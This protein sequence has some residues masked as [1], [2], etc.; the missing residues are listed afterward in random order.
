MS[1][2]MN[3]TSAA[4]TARRGTVAAFPFQN[5]I[6]SAAGTQARPVA[7]SG[8]FFDGGNSRTP[9]EGTHSISIEPAA[10]TSVIVPRFSQLLARIDDLIEAVS[11]P[12]RQMCKKRVS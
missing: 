5:D 12:T 3:R 10:K 6:I 4:L 1:S 8:Y 11:R 2:L 9:A 7:Y